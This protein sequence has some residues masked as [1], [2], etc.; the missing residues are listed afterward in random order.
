VSF[1]AIALSNRHRKSISAA[2]SGEG[3]GI[4][5]L[6]LLNCV[7]FFVLAGLRIMTYV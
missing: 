5:P 2:L 7:E 6:Q 3:A 1:A 4:V